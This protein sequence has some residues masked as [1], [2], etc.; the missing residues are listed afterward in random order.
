MTGPEPDVNPDEV[1]AALHAAWSGLLGVDAVTSA[2]NFYAGGG[3]SLTAALLLAKMRGKGASVRLTELVACTTFA[4]QLELFTAGHAATGDTA[5]ADLFAVQEIR[6]GQIVRQL[7]ASASAP[8]KALAL[9]LEITGDIDED[10]LSES[11]VDLVRRHDA[12][13]VG[14]INYN[15]EIAPTRTAVAD[16]WKPE[17]MDLS[18]FSREEA[19]AQVWQRIFEAEKQGL[20]FD[21]TALILGAVAT[22]RPDLSIAVLVVDHL[23]CDAESLGI[24]YADLAEIHCAKVEGRQPNLPDLRNA[25]RDGLVEAPRYSADESPILAA[26]WRDLI[27]GYPEPPAFDLLGPIGARDYSLTVPSRA[28]TLRFALPDGTATKLKATYR[29]LGV[30]PVAVMLAATY[31]AAHIVSGA[32][33][34]CIVNPRSRRNTVGARGVVNDFAEPSVIRIHHQGTSC[35]CEI[36]LAQVAAM[37]ASAYATASELEMPID[38]IRP[39]VTE[40]GGST[41]RALICSTLRATASAGAGLTADDALPWLWCSYARAE[42]GALRIGDAMATRLQTP[43]R[44]VAGVPNLY[45]YIDDD[46]TDIKVEITN[47]EKLYGSSVVSEFGAALGRVLIK[48]A[49]APDDRMSAS[50]PTACHTAM[51]SRPAA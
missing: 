6:L 19:Q 27:D 25:A 15:G 34:I 40:A 36:P 11:M 16:S 9:V 14:Y 21:T 30:P 23:V 37:A 10:L 7:R 45:M 31:L 3:T 48:L 51:G 46:G 20:A 28:G 13:N 8:V 22:V 44:G 43:S 47:P 4:E 42:S 29:R 12:L 5:E 18:G 26:K 33:D 50:T 38:L 39:F 32:Q 35:P 24:L 2:S 1:R 17:R 49:E 41:A